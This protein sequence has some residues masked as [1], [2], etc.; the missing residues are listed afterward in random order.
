MLSRMIA[1][2]S[3]LTLGVHI[4]ALPGMAQPTSAGQDEAFCRDLKR[5]V[6]A[7]RDGF[8]S[9]IVKQTSDTPDPARALSYDAIPVAGFESATITRAVRVTAGGKSK[10]AVYLA[11]YPVIR[12]SDPNRGAR[13]EIEN[14]VARC[15]DRPVAGD[16]YGHARFRTGDLEIG[17]RAVPNIIAD[18]F[19]SLVV[20]SPSLC[21]EELKHV[22]GCSPEP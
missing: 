3:V 14:Q 19:L 5:L 2:W 11:H 10:A 9:F 1:L 17:I 4:G 18:I 8:S 6:H 22:L 20:G 7:A 21:P 16:R 12:R 15:L 13:A